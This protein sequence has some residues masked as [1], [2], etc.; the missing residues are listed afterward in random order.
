MV[1]STSSVRPIS[2]SILPSWASWLRFEVYLSSALPPSPSRSLFVA[3]LFLGGFFLGDLRQAVRNEIDDVEARDLGAIQQVNGVT[4]LLAEDGD[5]HI[6]DADFFLA[7][8]L[9]VEHRALQHALEAERGLHL[10]VFVI[11][12]PRRGAVEVLVERVLEPVDVAPQ[13]RRISRT[14]GVSRIDS[15]RCSTV[16]NS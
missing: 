13:A 7:G 6:G 10:A 3:G 14:L 12:Q 11:G 8:G 4:L 2:G 1:R 5:E 16:R 15:S 9:H